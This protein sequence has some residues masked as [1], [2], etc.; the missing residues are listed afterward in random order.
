MSYLGDLRKE[1][2]EKMKSENGSMMTVGLLEQAYV[3]DHGKCD[4]CPNTRNLTYDHLL[5][6]SL[7]ADFNID[8]RKEFWEENG[9]VLC[10]ACNQKK[11]NRFDF[12]TPKTKE[13]LLKLLNL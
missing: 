12:S 11:A 5:P 8:A 7:L 9:R 6:K 2:K 1:L 4:L 13:L 10:Y 3:K